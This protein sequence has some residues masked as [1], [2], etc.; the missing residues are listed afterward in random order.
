MDELPE[1]LKKALKDSPRLDPPESF[2]RG[3][4]DKIEKPR[5]GRL[6]GPG[7]LVPKV[8]AGTCLAMLAVFAG[9]EFLSDPPAPA[10][11]PIRETSFAEEARP[12]AP[13]VSFKK[14][15]PAPPETAMSDKVTEVLQKQKRD[16]AP[17]DVPQASSWPMQARDM[18]GIASQKSFSYGSRAKK[19]MRVNEER[20]AG[21]SGAAASLVGASRASDWVAP[22]EGL[23][24]NWQGQHSAIA[25]S[26]QV[27]V[28]DAGSWRTLWN[29]HAP[30]EPAPP[31]DF[32]RNMV[33]GVFLG[34][35][36]N[37]GHELRITDLKTLP[38]QFALEYEELLPQEGR[39][40][41]QIM[42]RPYALKV[43]PKTDLH[44]HF[45]PLRPRDR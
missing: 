7:A 44:I 20:K 29:E 3:V 1:K 38:D 5:Q 24:M 15:V 21:V 33:V 8:V 6:W 41:A 27:I 40:Y 32:T 10:L 2:Y 35:R 18:S 42:V 36:P 26:R 23:S 30:G 43:I 25:G 12:M 28:R 39:M 34:E 4:M 45:H 31:V 37:A 16:E 17:K 13:G 11:R 19:S 9:R 14:A 22:L